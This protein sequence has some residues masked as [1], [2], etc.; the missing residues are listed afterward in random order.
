M[1]SNPD[2]LAYL[3]SEA[4]TVLGAALALQ[5]P[6][7]FESI[8]EMRDD[9][10][11]RSQYGQ[12]HRAGS[13]KEFGQGTKRPMTQP[14]VGGITTITPRQFGE[15]VS[16]LITTMDEAR[17]KA[18]DLRSLI[19]GPGGWAASYQTGRD[20]LACGILKNGGTGTG[21]DGQALFAA[22]HP[23][24][25]KFLDGASISNQDTTG[26]AINPTAVKAAHMAFAETMA[27]AENGEQIDN[28]P[29]DIVVSRIQ[30]YHEM[31]AV[32]FSEK[33]AGVANNDVN[34][35]TPIGFKLSHWP[36]V[37]QASGTEYWYMLKAQAGLLFVDKER[38]TAD[39][40]YDPENRTYHVG[41]AYQAEAGYRD[42]RGAYRVALA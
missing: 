25:S 8:F 7:K 21:Y 29:T 31:Y 41:P 13:M 18:L 32:L 17:A 23:Q 40:W 12:I 26:Q 34:S 4:I 39:T 37:K 24:R 16:W 36:R 6:P 22:A 28:T 19:E 42:F 15:E 1:F 2:I 30:D 35:L 3:R 14:F 10:R 33:I 20:K 9:A 38:M 5:T 11:E 27:I